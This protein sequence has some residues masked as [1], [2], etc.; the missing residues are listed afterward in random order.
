MALFPF[1][2]LRKTGADTDPVILNHER[3]HLRQQLELLI[4]PFYLIYLLH[5]FFLLLRFRN[6]EKAYRNIV[7]EREA[8]THEGDPTYLSKRRWWAA[9]G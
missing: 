4:L 9:F 1:I 2:L 5:Y 8:Y 6:H 3:I 7:F